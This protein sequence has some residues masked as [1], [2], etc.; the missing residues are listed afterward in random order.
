MNDVDN[1]IKKEL[2]EKPIK[3]CGKKMTQSQAITYLGEQISEKGVAASA[4]ETIAKRYGRAK[5]LILEIKAIIE[6]CRSNREGAI[7]TGIQLF[8]LSVVPYIYYSSELWVS[9]PP[10]SIQQLNDLHELL[11]RVMFGTS[12]SCPKVILCSCSCTLMTYR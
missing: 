2:D 5:Q 7:F 8:Q 1:V 12:K 6:D 11:Y 4:K 3:L 10:E 9:I